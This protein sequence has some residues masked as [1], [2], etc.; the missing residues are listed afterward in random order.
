MIHTKELEKKAEELSQQGIH[1]TLATVVRCES[2]T[3]SKPGA[4]ALVTEAGD[5]FGWIGGGC[6]QPAVIKTVK[7]CIKTGQPQLIRVT[8]THEASLE[9]GIVNFNMACHSGGTLDI[10]IEPV[11]IKPLLLIIG[12][13]PVARALN[14]LS[15]IAGFETNIIAR[16]ADA[17]MF[18]EASDISSSM[19]SNEIQLQRMPYVVVS[20]QG[21]ADEVGL[22]TALAIGS[23]Y[24]ALVASERKAEKLI[25]K[26]TN[27]GVNKKHLE[28]LRYPAGI[29]IEARSP[30]EI[31]VALLAEL[32]SVKNSDQPD[33]SGMPFPNNAELSEESESGTAEAVDTTTASSGGCCSQS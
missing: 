3:S 6:A 14:K 11:S 4:K 8:P 18:P 7:E 32:I 12:S 33:M 27:K 10:F 9:D 31:A 16:D 1:Y 21:K 29:E 5:I 2:P 23:P 15:N 24:T 28:N 30:E 25:E 13:S 19:K 20:T 17:V 26:L 22:K